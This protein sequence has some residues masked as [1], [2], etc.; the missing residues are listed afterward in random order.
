MTQPSG[1]ELLRTDFYSKENKKE[2]ELKKKL[3][4]MKYEILILKYL[5]ELCTER[6][7]GTNT[8]Y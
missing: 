6:N 2:R 1:F 8:T 3:A 4:P 5:Y 7:L